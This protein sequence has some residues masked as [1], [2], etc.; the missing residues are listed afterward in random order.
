MA[1]KKKP[2]EKKSKYSKKELAR[3]RKSLINEKADILEGLVQLKEDSLKKSVKDASG[4]ISG[5]TFHMADMATDLY[6]RE[7]I[8]SLAE[9]EREMLYNLDDAIK[10][11][12]SGKYGLCDMCGDMIGKQRIKAMPQAKCCI[13]CQKKRELSDQG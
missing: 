13:K 9:G 11:I 1:K 3:I 2:E 4:D 5:Y 6:D 8:L 12:D 10:R 7:F